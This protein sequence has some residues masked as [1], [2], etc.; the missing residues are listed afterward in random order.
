MAGAGVWAGT[1][2]TGAGAGTHHIGAGAGILHIGE[3]TTAGAAGT[4]TAGMA[5]MADSDIHSM[6][7]ITMASIMAD[8][9]MVLLITA[10]DEIQI[11]EDQPEIAED[12]RIQELKIQGEIHILERPAHQWNVLAIG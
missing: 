2:H 5:I 9:A 6:A 10:E 8:M 3:V 7:G 12:L 11:M 1:H 4:A